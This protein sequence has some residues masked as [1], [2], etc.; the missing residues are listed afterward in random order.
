MVE[1]KSTDKTME[2]PKQTI[3]EL[4]YLV[5]HCLVEEFRMNNRRY[6]L[7]EC[8]DKENYDKLHTQFTVA[9]IWILK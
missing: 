4:L 9:F 3:C 1:R 7:M 6:A 5:L 2:S 8:D